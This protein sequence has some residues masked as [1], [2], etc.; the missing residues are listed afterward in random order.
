M[1]WVLLVAGCVE[2]VLTGPFA[3]RK[4]RDAKARQIAEEEYSDYSDVLLLIDYIDGELAVTTGKEI[5]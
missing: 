5:E 1:Y 2:P 3:T 4:E